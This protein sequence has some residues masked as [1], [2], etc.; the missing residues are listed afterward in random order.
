M[1]GGMRASD[2]ERDACIEMLEKAYAEGRLNDIERQHRIDSALAAITQDDLARLTR[3]L[4]PRPTTARPTTGT[5]TASVNPAAVKVVVGFVIGLVVLGIAV[6]LLM[7]S[8]GTSTPSMPM[9]QPN[10]TPPPLQLHTA[11]G[12]AKFKDI[13]GDKFGSTEVTT[14]VLYPDYASVTVPVAGSE[15]RLETWSFRGQF[16]DEPM[17]LS[18]RSSFDSGNNIDISDIDVPVMLSHLKESPRALNVEDVKSTYIVIDSHHDEDPGYSIYASNEYSESGYWRFTLDG[19]ET[20]RY[21]FSG[22]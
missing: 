16:G 3:D 20:R 1:P 7:H 14:L 17:S 11:D 6:P 21:A 4:G 10:S 15:S 8:G 2:A 22:D 19:K 18:S 13:M 12:F 9:G 5:A